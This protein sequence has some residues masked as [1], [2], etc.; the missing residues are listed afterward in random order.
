VDAGPEH[1][2]DLLDVRLEAA[3]EPAVFLVGRGRPVWHQI[4]LRL[5]LHRAFAMARRSL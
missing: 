4:E 3:G 5:D 2:S 1:Q